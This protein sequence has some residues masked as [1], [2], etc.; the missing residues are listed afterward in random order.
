MQW[1]VEKGCGAV[2]SARQPSFP[3]SKGALLHR[4]MTG[5]EKKVTFDRPTRLPRRRII[6]LWMPEFVDLKNHGCLRRGILQGL[7]G[8]RGLMTRSLS[9]TRFLHKAF[10][11]IQLSSTVSPSGGRRASSKCGLQK[12]GPCGAAPP[13]PKWNPNEE[14]KSPRDPRGPLADATLVAHRSR[15]RHHA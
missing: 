11:K 3:T 10:G 13:E 5:R 2:V 4:R 15:A 12:H 6:R 1:E 8:L 9:K 14:F 7:L